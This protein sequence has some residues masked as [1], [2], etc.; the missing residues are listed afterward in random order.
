MRRSFVA[1]W[2]TAEV[3]LCGLGG[4]ETSWAEDRTTVTDTAGRR[5]EVPSPPGRIIC[6]SPGALRQI[7]YLGAAGKVV[8]VEGLEKNHPMGRPYWLAHPELAAL[9]VV[10]PGGP[11]SINGEPDLEA[12]LKVKPDV[13]FVTY[14]ESAKA[15]ALQK[16]LGIPVV[17]L[18]YGRFE[19]F[20]EV[21]YDSLRVA[22]KALNAESRA[23]DVIAF[24]QNCKGDLKKKTAGLGAAATAGVYAGAVGFKGTQGIESTD[25][26]YPP[27]EWVNANN[28]AQRSGKQGHLFIDKEQLLAWDPEVIF[29]DGGGLSLVRQD[30]QK[31]AELYKALRAVKNGRV[32]LLFPFNWYMTNICT[33]I[34]DAYA[35]GK[36]LYP[37]RFADIDLKRKADEVYTFFVGKPVYE[38]ME[39]DFGELGSPVSLSPRP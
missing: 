7:C 39:R 33:T 17:V 16:K 3:I 8:G 5:V 25:A 38:R 21:V 1:A 23:A 6:L 29:I 24:A 12:V 36:V 35:V 31:K 20:D 15:D 22:G 27:L 19:Q 4:S 26:N 34:I 30:F 28:V 13:I 11:K 37:D 14:M 18:T 9:P 2:V 32:Y 10:G